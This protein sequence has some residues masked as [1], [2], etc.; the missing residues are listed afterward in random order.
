MRRGECGRVR[1]DV[2]YHVTVCLRRS[3]CGRVRVD[4]V[5][6]VTVYFEEG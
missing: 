2:V 1:V 4:V 3:E 5:Y 6:H